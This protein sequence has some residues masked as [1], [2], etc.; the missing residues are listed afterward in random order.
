MYIIMILVIVVPIVTGLVIN[1]ETEQKPEQPQQH[2]E[3][4]HDP[5][6]TVPR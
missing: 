2:Q 4:Q 6:A 3:E 5:A 1:H